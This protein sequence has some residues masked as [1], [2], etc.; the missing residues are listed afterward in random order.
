V[1]NDI[2][3]RNIDVTSTKPKRKDIEDEGEKGKDELEENE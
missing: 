2:V 1:R 3:A